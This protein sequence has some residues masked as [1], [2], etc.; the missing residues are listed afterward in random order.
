MVFS[1]N[2]LGL[3]GRDVPTYLTVLV[4]ETDYLKKSSQWAT[5]RVNGE[6]VVPFCTPQAHCT[7]AWYHC[8]LDVDVTER[9]RA[10]SGGT[11][12]VEV[13]SFGVEPGPCDHLGYPLYAK[14]VVTDEPLVEDERE[15][16]INW[17]FLAAVSFFLLM[18]CLLFL[19]VWHRRKSARVFIKYEGN[20][21][22][23]CME[24]EDIE[25][26]N[27]I[28]LALENNPH[29]PQTSSDQFALESMP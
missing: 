12:E 25:N 3:A 23:F 5:V 7:E 10:A 4:V 18:F 13:S 26:T 8:M 14:V 1:L 11:L 16:S 22:D 21:R 6:V 2:N 27:G 28:D 9:L 29:Q 24:N 19:V 15:L 17:L 20:S